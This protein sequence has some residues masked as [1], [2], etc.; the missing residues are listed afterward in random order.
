MIEHHL[1]TLPY[2]LDALAPTLS[3]E[4]LDLHYNKHHKSYFDK[5]TVLLN[6]PENKI[7]KDLSLEELVRK[8][9]PGAVFNNAGQALNHNFYWQCLTPDATKNQLSPSLER[10]IIQSFGS[11][12]DFKSQFNNAAASQ[13][14]SGWAWLTQNITGKLQIETTSNAQTPFQKEKKCLLTCDVWEHAYYIDYRNRRPD[15]LAA[16]WEIVNWQFVHDNLHVT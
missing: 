3:K 6:M 8:A 16:F 1:P 15:Y 12:E 4:A 5:L 14:G 7:F 10:L 11:I 13:F 9:P 2:A